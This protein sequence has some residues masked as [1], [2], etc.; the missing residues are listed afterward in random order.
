MS[1]RRRRVGAAISGVGLVVTGLALFPVAAG[2]APD[3]VVIDV[4]GAIYGNPGDVIVVQEVAVDPALVGATCDGVAI[5]QNNES[6]HPDTDLIVSTG[7]TQS[8]FA[9]VESVSDGVT[10]GTEHVVL[11]PTITVSVR[12]GADGVASG[13]TRLSLDC[14]AIAP[15][16]TTTTPTTAPPTTA[17]PTTAPPTT[18]PPTTAPPTT[19]PT[20][21]PPTTTP[22]TAPS[23][24]P[25]AP[26]TSFEVGPQVVTGP[27]L[28]FTG[29]GATVPLVAV[30]L[31]LLVVGLM[32]RQI[33]RRD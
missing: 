11:G 15:T 22:P 5:T 7:G 20:T 1:S 8:E 24:A 32:L 9:D 3:D 19:A 17:P 33:P 12:L 23:T 29:S 25:E 2:A 30:G 13:G 26:P 4:T 21:A 18:A 10:E 28:P 27:E 16:T 14:Q 6:V 31:A